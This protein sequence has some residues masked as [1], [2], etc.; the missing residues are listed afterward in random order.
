MKRHTTN[1]TNCTKQT[2]LSGSVVPVA[3]WSHATLYYAG[4][5]RIFMKPV[6]GNLI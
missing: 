2:E 5:N 4:K 1:S 3:V 6:G